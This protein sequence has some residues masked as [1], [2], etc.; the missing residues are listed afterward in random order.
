MFASEMTNTQSNA[1]RFFSAYRVELLASIKRKP[2]QYAVP[3]D[4]TQEQFADATADK[5][6]TAMIRGHDVNVSDA[7]RRA[8]RK[9]GLPNTRRETIFAFIR[10]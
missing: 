4:Q 10:S 1:M 8:A 5:M 6:V 2:T 9:L 7:M 3:S